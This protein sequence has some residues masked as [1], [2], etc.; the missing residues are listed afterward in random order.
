MSVRKNPRRFVLMVSSHSS[1]VISSIGA[2]MPLM[3]ALAIAMS[4]PPKRLHDPSDCSVHLI[5]VAYVRKE[6]DCVPAS[7]L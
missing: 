4:M 3:P 7:G 6:V 5:R 2:W 1:G